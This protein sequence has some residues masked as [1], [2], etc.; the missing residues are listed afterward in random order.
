[1]TRRPA[2]NRLL[3]PGVPPDGSTAEPGEH[4]RA[5][6]PSR[7][8][9]TSPKHAPV[10]SPTKRPVKGLPP[11]VAVHQLSWLFCP[12]KLATAL[13]T[14]RPQATGLLRRELDDTEVAVEELVAEA[15]LELLALSTP[16]AGDPGATELLI[17]WLLETCR[18]IHEEAVRQ[19]AVLISAVLLDDLSRSNQ[20]AL[21]APETPEDLL[22]IKE[23]REALACL[24]DLEAL[25]AYALDEHAG[26]KANAVR[27][28]IFTARG[29]AAK[30]L[31]ELGWAALRKKARAR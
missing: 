20:A 26:K 17:H 12:R 13:T 23:A 9:P 15:E 4:H 14:A 5:K 25:E 19:D 2:K 28:R 18:R 3:A 21:I 11:S 8:Y 31:V 6:F 24:I 1:M 29:K 7:G 22:L 30:G 27:A 10:I 16:A